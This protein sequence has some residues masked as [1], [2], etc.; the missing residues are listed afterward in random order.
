MKSSWPYFWS[1]F[2]KHIHICWLASNPRR[3][4]KMICWT[5]RQT[6]AGSHVASIIQH[7][8]LSQLEGDEIEESGLARMQDGQQG[9]SGQQRRTFYLREHP[10]NH[11]YFLVTEIFCRIFHYARLQLPS[12]VILRPCWFHSARTASPVSLLTPP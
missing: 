1:Y 9:I 10:W 7:G 5:N 12:K 6:A 8:H 11:P 4:R 2:L 3:R